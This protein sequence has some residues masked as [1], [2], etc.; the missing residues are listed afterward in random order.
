MS[1]PIAPIH[2]PVACPTAGSDLSPA[3][4]RVRMRRLPYRDARVLA[5][6]RAAK[7]SA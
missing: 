5:A 2:D 7:V 1:L 3:E 6:L 4:R